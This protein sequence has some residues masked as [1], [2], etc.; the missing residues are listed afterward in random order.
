LKIAVAGL[1][2]GILIWQFI[3]LRTR[4]AYPKYAIQYFS[5]IPCRPALFACCTLGQREKFGYD[6]PLLVADIHLFCKKLKTDIQR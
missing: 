4:A 3:P 6:P 1:I 5:L 2:G